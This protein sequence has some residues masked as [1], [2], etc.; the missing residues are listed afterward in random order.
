MGKRSNPSLHWWF[1]WVVKSFTIYQEHNFLHKIY[2]KKKQPQNFMY[3]KA[4]KFSS[5]V[6]G[7][8]ARKKSS[9]TWKVKEVEIVFVVLEQFRFLAVWLNLWVNIFSSDFFLI[10]GHARFTCI[11]FISIMCIFTSKAFNSLQRRICTEC[12]T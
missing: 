12:S 10:L 1:L 4:L 2:N 9:Q 8:G 5:I 7:V 6:M 3:N 11:S